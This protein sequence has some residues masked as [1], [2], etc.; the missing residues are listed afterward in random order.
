[1][2]SPKTSNQ[3]PWPRFPATASSVVTS[4]AVASPTAPA[5]TSAV[6]RA[7][8]AGLLTI[9]ALLFIGGGHDALASAVS[10]A[11]GVTAALDADLAVLGGGFAALP[12][13]LESE[14]ADAVDS[15]RAATDAAQSALAGAA[16]GADAPADAV[17]EG[18]A[19]LALSD[20]QVAL[21]AAA[22]QV[23]HVRSQVGDTPTVSEALTSLQ[24][25]L[26]ALRLQQPDAS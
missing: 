20:A 9:A 25:H 13:V 8:T 26:D 21:E 24:T 4:S 14:V 7:A 17:E 5:P 23:R 22:A 1:M 15:A 18:R 11:R 6:A 3:A 19:V 10:D 2:T 12:S 16:R